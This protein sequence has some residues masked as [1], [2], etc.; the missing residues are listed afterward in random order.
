MPFAESFREIV[1]GRRRGWRAA[2]LRKALAAGEPLYRAAVARRNQRFDH[3]PAAIQRAGVPVI[4]VGNLT[5]GGTGKTPFVAWLA[6]QLRDSGRRVGIISRG[7]GA[8]PGQPNDEAL[9]LALLLPDVPHLQNPDRVMA[10]RQAVEEKHCDVLVLDDAFQHR[11]LHRD[12]DIV[13]I[14]AL[15]PFG[16][17]HLLPRGLLREPISSLARG[18]IAVISRA[19]LVSDSERERIKERIRQ[20][21]P[22]MLMI[23]I[24]Q[25]A[26]CLLQW[27]G[28]T[29]D[30]DVLRGARI[31]AFCGIGNPLAFR[32]TLR[33]CG[34]EISDFREYS[35]HFA[36][37]ENEIRRLC[38]W[39]ERS[40]AERVVCTLK[41]L[42]KLRRETLGR[43]PLHA[44]R[45]GIEFFSQRVALEARVASV[46][47]RAE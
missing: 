5:T 46:L 25:R 36:F 10:A 23:E 33:Q 4:S 14:D 13:L 11:R 41:D 18:H 34:A 29:L 19:N 16:F 2:L 24:G 37:S 39:A 45:I 43:V 30:L 40:G 44:L 27:S 20:A 8:K 42:V 9:E 28:T 32:E 26:S 7:Y 6:G 3:D 17:D 12:L 22:E 15:E 1:S 38:D 35:D 21:A 31:A 47:S